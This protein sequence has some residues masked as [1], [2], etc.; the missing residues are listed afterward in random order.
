MRRITLTAAF[1]LALTGT[2][3]AGQNA[4]RPVKNWPIKV[5]LLTRAQILQKTSNGAVIVRRGSIEPFQVEEI[6]KSV[7][8]FKTQ[9]SEK[10]GEGYQVKV[11][12]TEDADSLMAWDNGGFVSSKSNGLNLTVGLQGLEPG[13]ADLHDAV[14]SRINSDLFENN[15]GYYFGPYKMVYVIHAGLNGLN[16]KFSVDGMPV[17]SMGYY[18]F[19]D[20]APA[21]NMARYMLD[22]HQKNTGLPA[23]PIAPATLN[24]TPYAM[25][26]MTLAANG[27]ELVAVSK[28]LVQR[29]GIVMFEAAGGQPI[30]PASSNLLTFRMQSESKDEISV[31]ALGDKGQLLGIAT[32]RGVSRLPSGATT[33]V[34]VRNVPSDKDFHDVKVDLAKLSGG[35]KIYQLRVGPTPYSKFFE[36][37]AF[38]QTTFRLMDFKVGSGDAGPESARPALP[39]DAAAAFVSSVSGSL[40]GDQ[41]NQVSSFMSQGGNSRLTAISLFTRVKDVRSLPLLS[42]IAKS[43][44]HSEAFLACEALAFQE[45]PDALSILEGIMRKG[46]FEANQ[47]FAAELFA[48]FPDKKYLPG[49]NLMMIQRGWRTRM[50]AVEALAAIKQRE[51]EIVLITSLAPQSEPHP[52]VRLRIAQVIDPTFDLAARRLLFAAVNDPSQWVRATAAGRLIDSSFDQIRSDALKTVKDDSPTVRL[53]L[54]GLMKAGAKAEYRPALRLA[55]TDPDLRVRAAALDAFAAQPD[56]VSS[57]E[58]QNT[59]EDT[60]EGVE[61]AL[62]NLAVAKKISLPAA[63]VTR[64]KGSNN[65]KIRQA[66]ANL[67]G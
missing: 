11:D 18:T 38:E 53:Y 62:V 41:W 55:V 32:L 58:I 5:F 4:Q 15:E 44:L 51:S 34:Q 31:S 56:A 35:E 37:Q 23:E 1:A 22:T 65:E 14:A 52:A 60:D 2:L 25:G 9:L 49:L 26:D 17:V 54:L 48:K 66:A 33:P 27:N 36:R 3:F 64:L 39:E 46:P 21:T 59:F 45:S 8:S 42:E 10:L 47:R 30:D 13:M 29:G 12:I 40:T 63:V 28:G 61:L 16:Q 43:A 7:D 6:K 19:S 67:P 57:T 20:E 50:A 24:R